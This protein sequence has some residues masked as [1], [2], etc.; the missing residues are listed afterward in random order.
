MM[1]STRMRADSVLPCCRRDVQLVKLYG[2]MN[3]HDEIAW[4]AEHTSKSCAIA[5]RCCLATAVSLC[6]TMRR[7]DIDS[8]R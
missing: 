6:W 8:L 3:R 2:A 7:R 1:F 5:R 4:V